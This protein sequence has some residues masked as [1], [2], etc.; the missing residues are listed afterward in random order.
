MP[1]ITV[2]TTAKTRYDIPEG[3]GINRLRR[4]AL[5]VLSEDDEGTDAVGTLHRAALDRVFIGSADVRS[6]SVEHRITEGN[7]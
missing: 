2:T 4:L 6:M 1:V 5:P 7:D 3:V